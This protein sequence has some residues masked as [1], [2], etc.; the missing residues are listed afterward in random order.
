MFQPVL[1]GQTAGGQQL[2]QY[3]SGGGVLIQ[4]RALGAGGLPLRVH[5]HGAHGVKAHGQKGAQVYVA[6]L[7]RGAGVGVDAADHAQAPLAA[8][9]TQVR[10]VDG[11]RPADEDIGDLAVS[12]D[13]QGHLPVEGGRPAAQGGKHF[14]REKNV[15]FQLKV[16]QGLHFVQNAFAD[17]LD[18]SMNIRHRESFLSIKRK[19]MG[20]GAQARPQ[21]LHDGGQDG[22]YPVDL[23][24]GIVPAK[25]KTHATAGRIG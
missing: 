13:V 22:Q 21:V 5:P 3:I 6:E 1:L 12:G 16:V 19:G 18:V 25:R 17:P 10:Q 2:R 7:A 11:V 9:E 14:L 4:K 23:F 20:S 24:G 8:A 15:R